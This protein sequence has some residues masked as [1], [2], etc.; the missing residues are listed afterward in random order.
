MTSSRRARYRQRRRRVP[1]RPLGGREP[2][3][4]RPGNGRELLPTD[5]R[6]PKRI[7]GLEAYG[8]QARFTQFSSRIVSSTPTV[9]SS[10]CTASGKVATVSLKHVGEDQRDVRDN[11]KYRDMGSTRPSDVVT[12]LLL[13]ARRAWNLRKVRLRTSTSIVETRSEMNSIQKKVTV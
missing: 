9:L 13:P 3:C 12:H 5:M 6:D 8:L 10:V 11:M 2:W 4:E 7:D 1:L